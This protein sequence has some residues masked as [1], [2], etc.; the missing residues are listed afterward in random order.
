MPLGIAVLFWLG[1]AIVAAGLPWLS[2]RWWLVA[3][4]N[5]IRPKPF[6]LRLLEW[7]LL[8]GFMLGLGLGL[9]Y[10]AT[11]AVHVQDWE[12]Y[13]VTLCLFAVSALPGF[14]Y[15]HQLRRLLDQAR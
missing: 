11:G 8:Y 13:A 9:E 15:R 6:W 7:L 2:E 1:V 12:F 4:R 14:A 3:V 5:D 10:K